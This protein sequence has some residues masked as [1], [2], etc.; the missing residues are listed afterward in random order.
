MTDDNQTQN[1]QNTSG[2]SQPIVEP[3]VPMPVVSDTQVSIPAPVTP[4]VTAPPI[5]NEASAQVEP[6]APTPISSVPLTSVNEPSAQIAVPRSETQ[7]VNE[8]V[9]NPL[10]DIFVPVIS[11]A[12]TLAPMT[13]VIPA[14]IEPA[15]P[16]SPIINE[17]PAPTVPEVPVEISAPL[18]PVVTT[19]PT[20]GI[21]APIEIQPTDPVTSIDHVAS[22]PTPTPVVPVQ[23]TIE[24]PTPLSVPLTPT[25]EPSAPIVVPRSETPVVNEVVP[26]PLDDIFAPV[27]NE[28]PAS[29]VPVT[30]ESVPAQVTPTVIASPIVNETPTPISVPVAPIEISVTPK[31]IVTTEPT[32]KVPAPIEIKPTDPVGTIEDKNTDLSFHEVPDLSGD[33]SIDLNAPTAQEIL[34]NPGIVT[35]AAKPLVTENVDNKTEDV[36]NVEPST[37]VEN[38]SIESIKKPVNE[39]LQTEKDSKAKKKKKK[40]SKVLLFIMLGLLVL[41]LSMIAIGVMTLAAKEDPSSSALFTALGIESPS[42]MTFVFLVSS[43]VF[44]IFTLVAFIAGIISFLKFSK[45]QK[46]DKKLKKKRLMAVILSF[47]LMIVFIVGLVFTSMSINKYKAPEPIQQ[48]EVILTDPLDTIGLT[49]PIDIDFEVANLPIDPTQVE[50]IGYI[51]EFG[52]GE[53]ATGEQVKHNFAKKPADGIYE[54][55]LTIQYKENGKD[56]IQT[57]IYTKTISIANEAVSAMF[58]ASPEEG[59]VP[60]EVVFDASESFDPDGE[61]VMY[62]WDYDGDGVYEGEGKV[63]TNTY[64]ESGEFE[65]SLRLTDSN[66]SQTT[67]SHTIIAKG[68]DIISF[69]LKLDP[70]DEILTPNLAY[71]FDASESTSDEGNILN[72]E[73]TFGD[74]GTGTGQ[75]YSYA[76]KE[77]GLYTVTATLTDEADNVRNFETEIKVSKSSSGL[78][79]RIQTVPESNQN[80]KSLLGTAPLKV[81]FSG[82]NSSGGNIVDYAWDFDGDGEV[83]KNGQTV[84]YT[85]EK[86]GSYNVFLII[87]SDEEKEARETM[88]IKVES[89][90]LVSKINAN[91]ATGVV[92][93][94]VTFDASSSSKPDDVEIVSYQWDFG[95]GTPINNSGA[96][97]THQ[98]TKIGTFHPTLLIIDSDNNF[99]KSETVIHINSIPLEACYTLS[100]K[101]GPAPLFV[102]FNPTCSTGSIDSFAW[103]FAGLGASEV[104]KPDYTF[105]VPGTYEITLEVSDKDNNIAEFKD[106]VIVE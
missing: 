13:P 26:N 41:I 103:D 23:V 1:N 59:R 25:N 45:T 10:D 96:R 72:Y 31:P 79:A 66:G 80:D 19:E 82:G 34:A 85:F 60:L 32:S 4:T 2:G 24:A 40:K 8:V 98:Y 71:Q 104:I 9:P 22:I 14:P 50:I 20:N 106:T 65:A 101:I 37:E 99:S 91:P 49:T 46:E 100:R 95:D 88:T 6:V 75:K 53:R 57:E 87:K 76:Y 48:L 12:P 30:P 3:V 27:I 63:T 94:N 47:G 93:V 11:D 64:E 35:E 105:N 38:N 73:W 81:N 21:P 7:V 43:I 33:I 86:A 17:A 90:G 83:D 15:A 78:F 89:A 77:E 56:S 44:G 92:P 28:A 52:D 70:A 97:I 54:V 74:G 61:I 84:D 42:L 68:E 36:V 16:A 39:S 5:A 102:E 58:T 62:E 67:S 18:K 29:V 69:K 55:S 51:W